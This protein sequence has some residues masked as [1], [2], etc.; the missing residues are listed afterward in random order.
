M[1]IWIS[2]TQNVPPLRFVNPPKHTFDQFISRILNEKFILR[3]FE[4][5]L[6]EYMGPKCHQN[7]SKEKSEDDLRLFESWA[8]ETYFRRCE[9]APQSLNTQL[10]NMKARDS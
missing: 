1:K 6:G 8:T 10:L 4:A 5:E 2:K 9:E 7:S 3:L